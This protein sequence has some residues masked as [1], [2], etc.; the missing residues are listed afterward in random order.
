[1]LCFLKFMVMIKKYKTCK[2][3]AKNTVK[4]KIRYS[5]YNQV[6]ETHEVIRGHLSVLGVKTTREIV[7]IRQK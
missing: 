5:E 7:L 6:V 4:L 1:M 2:G 3:T